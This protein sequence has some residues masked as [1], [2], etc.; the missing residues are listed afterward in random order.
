MKSKTL[1]TSIARQI[2]ALHSL[3]HAELR[4]HYESLYGQ[5]PAPL[6]NGR[7]LIQRIAYKIQEKVFGGLSSSCMKHMAGKVDT[8]AAVAPTVMPGSRLVRTYKGVQ[9]EVTVREIGVYSY[10]GVDYSSL[11]AVAKVITKQ[12]RNGK[13]FFDVRS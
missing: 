13:E 8:V 12:N 1:E 7:M 2:Y 11:S 10:G 4:A 5:P 3:S 6:V 9:H